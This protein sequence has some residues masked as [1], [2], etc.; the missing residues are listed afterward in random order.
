MKKLLLALAAVMMLGISCK[1][2]YFDQEGYE[3]Y[4]HYGFPIDSIDAKQDWTTLL[5]TK[6]TVSLSLGTGSGYTVGVYADDPTSAT[7]TTLYAS[8]E[9]TDGATAQFTFGHPTSVGSFYVA[10]TDANQNMIV[11]QASLADSALSVAFTA[12]DKGWT[13]QTATT[14]RFTWRCCFEDAFPDAGD[15]DFN[16][17]VLTLSSHRVS[18]KCVSLTISLDAIGSVSA[19][20]AAAR[21][22]GLTE[23]DI[24]SVSAASKFLQ[25]DFSYSP[26]GEK[27]TAK[28]YQ[29]SN[30]NEIVI[31]IFND[32][33]YAISEGAMADDGSIYRAYYNTV[34]AA[35]DSR[36]STYA[37]T[38][39]PVEKTFYIWCKN[40]TVAKSIGHATID[41]F[42][43]T[44]YNGSYYETH[45]FPYKRE[46]TLC[47]WH[48]SKYKSVYDDNYPWA[49]KVPGYFKY[50]AEGIKIS[51]YYNN[52]ITGAYATT[53]HSFG[54]WAE[55]HTKAQDWYDY[56][57]SNY[58]Y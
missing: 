17:V 21:L 33:H 4:I 11:K 1:R 28:G 42:A 46:E 47:V 38:A 12:A 32:A 48:D 58:V 36:Y 10:L 34:G 2:D 3:E 16:D 41:V 44:Q 8:E 43:V 56:P 13:K 35:T 37:K 26:V 54:E 31:P 24:D 20:G 5:S 23:S 55:D 7:A 57:T 49:L 27:T 52:V 29:L 25:Y 22:V 45:C 15:Y 39:T 19:I 18:S 53:N 9:T 6:A 51:Y 50:P 40:E 14:E 30:D